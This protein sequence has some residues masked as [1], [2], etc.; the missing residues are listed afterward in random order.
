M[1]WIRSYS[2]SRKIGLISKT[3]NPQLASLSH[4]SPWHSHL[5]TLY[6]QSYRCRSPEE[7]FSWRHQATSSFYKALSTIDRS[8]LPCLVMT[9]RVA[10]SQPSWPFRDVSWRDFTKDDVLHHLFEALH[11]LRALKVWLVEI[12]H[13]DF[14]EIFSL[15]VNQTFPLFKMKA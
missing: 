11:G 9:W 2:G 10:M 8:K 4:F 3:P 7:V 1:P 5:L 13:D 12:G 14:G 6:I 15:F